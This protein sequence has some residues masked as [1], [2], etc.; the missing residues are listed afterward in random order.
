MRGKREES[1]FV[2]VSLCPAL[3]SLHPALMSGTANAGCACASAGY[4]ANGHPSSIMTCYGSH[5][6]GVKKGRGIAETDEK[7]LS[8]AKDA[9]YRYLTYR[10]RSRAEVEAKLRDKGFDEEV[11]QSAVSGLFRLGY[12]DDE[13]FAR[14]WAESR[15]R[16]RA[17]G[18]RR[19]ERELREKGIDP[20]IVRET[21]DGVF[22]ADQEIDIA[23]KAAAR[24]VKGM[25][26]LDR[27]TRRR[28][29]AGFLERKGFPYDVIRVVLKK[30]D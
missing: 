27:E 29:L 30:T 4:A 6:N 13:K 16:L 18:R 26:S 23:K 17:F 21:M 24:K 19:I 20:S 3:T 8:R 1:S 28:R 9:A 15:V 25:N 10:P 2:L 12:L 7:E 14:L 11:V 5:G 22:V